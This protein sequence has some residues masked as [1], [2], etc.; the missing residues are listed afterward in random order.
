MQKKCWCFPEVQENITQTPRPQKRVVQSIKDFQSTISSLSFLRNQD[1]KWSADH[2]FFWGFLFSVHK[3]SKHSWDSQ[4]HFIK[5]KVERLI[6]RCLFNYWLD[7]GK[8]PY[9]ALLPCHTS[10]I[11]QS[12][13]SFPAMQCSGHTGFRTEPLMTG[14]ISK[15]KLF[16]LTHIHSILLHFSKVTRNLLFLAFCLCRALKATQQI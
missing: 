3:I 16:K 11:P 5:G 15:T 9:K 8:A 13:C 6:S 12:S 7:W 4:F 2:S 1:Y 14:H 10:L